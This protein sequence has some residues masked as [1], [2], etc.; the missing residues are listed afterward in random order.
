MIHSASWGCCHCSCPAPQCLCIQ[1]TNLNSHFPSR[2]SNILSLSRSLLLSHTHSQLIVRESLLPRAPI[3]SSLSLCPFQCVCV[4][5][6]PSHT[7]PPPTLTNPTAN[8][9]T[10]THIQNERDYPYTNTAKGCFV[11]CLTC[12]H[13]PVLLFEC[14]LISVETELWMC[15]TS[16]LRTVCITS[17][18]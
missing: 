9:N 16:L 7:H 13:S 6:S 2:L 10:H 14:S 18:R 4:S 1:H 12:S 5:L 3:S 11:K 17:H 15:V 8:R